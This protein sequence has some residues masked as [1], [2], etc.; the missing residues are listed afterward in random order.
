MPAITS[1][2]MLIVDEFADALEISKPCLPDA[3]AAAD[4]LLAT[5]PPAS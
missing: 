3:L 1:P 2:L 4:R 5:T